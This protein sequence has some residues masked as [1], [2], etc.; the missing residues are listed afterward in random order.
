VK[1]L[2]QAPDTVRGEPQLAITHNNDRAARDNADAKIKALFEKERSGVGALT[3]VAGI[4]ARA[5]VDGAYTGTAKEIAERVYKWRGPTG[6]SE[7]SQISKLS[8]FNTVALAWDRRG[9]ELVEALVKLSAGMGQRYRTTQLILVMLK[10]R[11]R[12]NAAMPLSEELDE[13]LADAQKPKAKRSPDT[14]PNTLASDDFVRQLDVLLQDSD[15]PKDV[16]TACRKIKSYVEKKV[17][18]FC[19]VSKS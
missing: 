5:C 18:E 4:M 1:V 3:E 11:R 16:A 12:A 10:R 17:G 14:S 15:I 2:H 7:A 19:S 6:E 13:M 9:I 8:N